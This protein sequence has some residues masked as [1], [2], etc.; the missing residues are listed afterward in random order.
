MTMDPRQWARVSAL[1]EQAVDLRG[2]AREAFIAQHCGDEAALR[3]ALQAML[4][5][6][7][8]TAVVDAPLAELVPADSLVE[9]PSA[10]MGARLGP[11]RIDGMLGRG[12][13]GVVHLAH[14]EDDFSQKVAI[15]RLQQRWGSPGQAE[16]FLQERQILADLSHPYI[17][18][19]L[20]GGIDAQ[21]QPWF[22][23]EYV[24]GAPITQWADAQRLDLRGR[25]ALFA[26]ICEAVQHAHERF[27]V[28][29]D[30]KP[31]NILADAHGHP[32][33]LDFGVAKLVDPLAEGATRTGVAVGFTPEYAAPEQITGGA[34]TA[35]TDVYALGLVLYRLLT[36]RLPYDLAEHDLTARV[37]AIS[38]HAPMRPELAITSGTPAQISERLR[39]RD[40]DAAAF[41]RFVRGDL[42][43]ILQTALAKEPERRYGTVQAFANDLRHFLEGRPVSVSGDTLG[44]RARKF[45]RRN[46]W[47]VAMASLAVVA[48]SIG[49]TGI[50]LQTREARM[51][52]MR[53][54]AEATRAEGE[55]KR[56]D[57]INTF[58]LNV[59]AGASMEAGGRP[60]ISLR[61][62]LE[63]ALKRALDN[64]EREP[65][66]AVRVLLAAANSYGALGD[67]A[68]AKA[69]IEQGL[70]L[71]EARLPEAKADRGWLLAQR[72][73]LDEE[74]SREQAAAW[75]RE[76]VAL[77]RTAGHTAGLL[78]A[79]S[80]LTLALYG[81]DDH[82][83]ALAATD[84]SLAIIQR[85]GLSSDPVYAF[86]LSNRALLLG[87]LDRHD[88]ASETHRQVLD[89]A[90][91]MHGADDPN[92]ARLR[93]YYGIS[94]MQ[95]AA[96]TDALQAIE[97]ALAA[98]RTTLGDADENTQQ[99]V[100][101]KADT[102]RNLDRHAEALPLLQE[103]T[104]Y[105]QAKHRPERAE[106]ATQLLAE[107]LAHLGRCTEAHTVTS[108]FA[109]ASTVDTAN[110][111]DGSRCRR[112]R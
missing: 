99:A 60:D 69:L 85:D 51:Q 4:D 96:W 110:W 8:T 44:Y 87:Q 3:D 52:A 79:L 77:Q 111:L 82:E 27:V 75:A 97:D 47:G 16:R 57:G 31:D 23:M 55:V 29:R 48:M 17:A 78:D 39:E 54:Q 28:H 50:V 22:A 6:D 2:D 64:Q 49:A 100:L 103:T 67:N 26:K 25:I 30:L 94:L 95:A 20:D 19:L 72:S 83:G 88:E 108:D 34:I 7:A 13:M 14:R 92:V 109:A 102:L 90:I 41:R 18:R 35:A 80:A 43:R 32:R 62:A 37:D 71:Q 15:K 21:G 5:A 12:G 46:P 107:T 101:L 68:R 89:N 105:W 84:E 58:L 56:V 104:P 53:A 59:F 70:A 61:D 112:D 91:A 38:R 11:Y 63:L 66:I 76:A 42:T 106:R 74:V 93:L 98:M 24:E 33:V 36:G 73:H 1:F 45:I 65:E 86:A 40:I 9:E 81:V 10:A